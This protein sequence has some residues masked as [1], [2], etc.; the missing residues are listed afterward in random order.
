MATLRDRAVIEVTMGES[1][2][3]QTRLDP[4]R[5]MTILN[6]SGPISLQD[7]EYC[8][9]EI[10][11]ALSGCAAE[12]LQFGIGHPSRLA[13][14]FDAANIR[15]LRRALRERA[16]RVFRSR[17]LLPKVIA[18]LQQREDA[19]FQLATEIIAVGPMHA[20]PGAAVRDIVHSLPSNDRDNPDQKHRG[21]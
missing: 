16:G 19:L 18:T 14:R 9:E 20:L 15:P 2:L 10:E 5:I 1:G 8:I 21:A 6:A 7:Q 11:V 3:P 4:A 17:E 12:K 13:Y